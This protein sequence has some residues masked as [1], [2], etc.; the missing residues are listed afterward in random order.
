MHE[1]TARL[2]EV[3]VGMPEDFIGHSTETALQNGAFRGALL[4]IEGFVGLFS[5]QFNPLQVILTG[6]DAEFLK[7]QLQLSMVSI[8]PH[9]TLYGLNHILNHISRNQLPA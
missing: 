6:G 9:L 3:P 8:E 5:K 4:E 7:A 2:P 1:F